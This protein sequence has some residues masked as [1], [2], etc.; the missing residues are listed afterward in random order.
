MRKFG[1]RILV[2]KLMAMGARLDNIPRIDMAGSY[3][4][5]LDIIDNTDTSSLRSAI[6]QLCRERTKS[7]ITR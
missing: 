2:V 1:L 6:A 5:N 4:Y 3:H 7:G